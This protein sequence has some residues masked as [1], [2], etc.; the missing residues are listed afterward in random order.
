MMVP[1]IKKSDPKYLSRKEEIAHLPPAERIKLRGYRSYIGGADPERWYSI[2]R[3]QYHF[4]CANG[5]SP[6]SKF[7]DVGCGSLRLGQF[8]IPFLNTGNYY[9]LEPEELLV[10]CGIQH[11]INPEV[12]R[13]KKPKFSHNYNFDFDSLDY[14]DYSI[15][16]SILTHLT[17]DDIRMCFSKLKKKTR[18]AS[19]FYF[20]FFEGQSSTNQFSESHAN[21]DWR[22]AFEEIVSFAEGWDLDYIGDWN[23]PNHQKIVKATPK[24]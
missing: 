3:L 11:E 9:G 8:V 1:D 23:H 17:P 20:T 18:P 5:L 6:S 21:R 24:V 22:Y 10:Q 2:G 14:F 16:N 12:V 7:L 4:L 13:I 19:V 15:A